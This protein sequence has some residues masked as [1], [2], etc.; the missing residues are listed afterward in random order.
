[1]TPSRLDHIAC[2]NYPIQ[3]LRLDWWCYVR[4]VF[5]VGLV[6]HSHLEAL[7]ESGLVVVTFLVASHHIYGGWWVV[8]VWP[9]F[10]GHTSEWSAELCSVGV[11]ETEIR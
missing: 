6:S 5:H 1:M 7:C 3:S 2:G 8:S 4:L 11:L 9:A 10:C